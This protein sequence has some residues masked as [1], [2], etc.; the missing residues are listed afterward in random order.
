MGRRTSFLVEPAPRRRLPEDLEP[1]VVANER[2]AVRPLARVGGDAWSSHGLIRSRPPSPRSATAPSRSPEARRSCRSCASGSCAPIRSSTSAVP[3]RR[4]SWLEPQTRIGAG[5][6]LGELEVDPEIPEALREACRLSARRRSCAR[7]GRS[8]ATSSRRRDA[9]TGA[10]AF[11]AACT[12]S[13]MVGA[14]AA[15]RARASTASTRSSRT[16]SARP[17]I[18]PIRPPRCSRSARRSAPTGASCRSRS[19][20]ACRRGEP[21]DDD[22]RSRRADPRARRAAARREHVPEGDGPRALVVRARRRRGGAVRRRDAARA[23]RRRADPVGAALARRGDAAAR[24]TRTS[25]SS[26]AC[27]SSARAA[28]SVPHEARAGRSS[29]SCSRSASRRAAAATTRARATPAATT[30][31]TT[32]EAAGD[33]VR[34]RGRRKTKP[35]GTLSAPTEKLD[36]DKTYSLVF[37]T[38]CGSFTVELDQKLAPNDDGVAR[39][40]REA[41]TSS[42]TR[43]FHR[44][45]P[46]FVI[47]GG[48]PTGVRPRRARLQDRRPRRRRRRRTR[49]ASSRWRRPANEAPG[50]SGSQFFVVTADD[51]GLPPDYAVVGKVTDGL[52]VVDKI[53]TLGDATE[54]PTRDGR[55]RGRRRRDVL[56]W[57]ARSSSLPAPRHATARRSSACSARACSPRSRASSVDDVV[58]VARRAPRSTPTPASSTAPTGSAARARRCAAGSRALVD[59]VEAAVVVLADGPNLDPRAVDRVSTRGVKAAPTARGDVRRAQPLASRAARADCVGTRCPTRARAALDV[60]ARAVHG[61]HRAGRRR[62]AGDSAKSVRCAAARASP[63]APAASARPPLCGCS[64]AARPRSDSGVGSTRSPSRCPSASAISS[65][66]SSRSR[67]GCIISSH[68]SQGSN[69]YPL[70]RPPP[71][72][73]RRFRIRRARCSRDMTVPTGMSRICAVSA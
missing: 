35:D 68:L 42:T 48:D 28:R 10:C 61:P 2:R 67:Y 55:D 15:T 36:A 50:T 62:R 6:T 63:S 8:A 24:R 60:A 34:A 31:A 4:E 59:D 20:T 13:P 39:L 33:R 46:G 11:P 54:Q 30:T 1:E 53:G 45:V 14:T 17:R 41:A 43:S 57:S 70:T 37:E 19:C 12:V 65:T 18:R 7:P 71:P 25:S 44:I 64:A 38:N 5:T 51:A 72:Q 40:P 52:D 29:P 9:G 27:S 22:A 23:R 21:R 58:V 56:E 69:A 66:V 32:A 16:T 49:T 3:C 73:A 47:Q 26:R